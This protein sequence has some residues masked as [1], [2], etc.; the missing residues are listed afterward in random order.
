MGHPAR[1]HTQA[2]IRQTQTN[3][4]IHLPPNWQTCT[5]LHG[6]KH[7]HTHT[8]YHGS[9]RWFWSC[10]KLSSQLRLSMESFSVPLFDAVLVINSDKS[11]S[12]SLLMCTHHTHELTNTHST[13]ILSSLI[14]R[15]SG[16]MQDVST[17]WTASCRNCFKMS[18]W[19]S[20]F[21]M[22]WRACEVLIVFMY[23]ILNNSHP[24][25]DPENLRLHGNKWSSV[26]CKYV[27]TW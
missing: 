25:T 9:G 7:T 26:Q 27:S 3:R 15:E 21:V 10:D 6:Q 11:S 14:N 12:S 23:Q 2:H 1:Q 19:E 20:L 24:S 22:W 8:P 18:V 16:D 4:H 5:H 13:S 17:A